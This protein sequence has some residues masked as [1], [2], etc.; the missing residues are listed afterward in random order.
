MVITLY[1]QFVRSDYSRPIFIIFKFRSLS[2]YLLKVATCLFQSRSL[3]II[4]YFNTAI[5][6][7]YLCRN[8]HFVRF[9]KG[10]LDDIGSMC[11]KLWTGIWLQCKQASIKKC[12]YVLRYV[13]E[14]F[15][16]CLINTINPFQSDRVKGQ[17][18]ENFTYPVQDKFHGL[19]KNILN[20]PT[21]H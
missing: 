3:L 9:V 13:R 18:A 14:V 16:W 2:L 1:K 11:R 15:Y 5:H 17:R 7:S 20:A 4:L 12:E 21:Q 6:N 8:S 10:A 19:L